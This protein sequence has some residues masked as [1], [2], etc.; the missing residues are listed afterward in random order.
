[1]KYVVT[2]GAGFIGSHL[3]AALLRRGHDVTVVDNLFSGT[4][5]NLEAAE[6]EAG[7]GAGT[8][9]GTP[10]GALTFV[11]ADILD[12]AAMQGALEG[13]KAVFHQAAIASVPRSFAEPAPSLRVN[14]EGTAQL[15]EACR[16]QDVRRFV[17]ASSSS[18]YGDTPT[19]P[20]HEGM[21]LTPLSPYAL[22][23]AADEHL[24]AIWNRQYG[25]ET[26]GL[27]Y[28]NIF[29]PR[30]DP[31]S[32][33]AAV[34][35]KFITRMLDGSAP[36]I[37]GDGGQSRDFTFIDNAVTANLYAGGVEGPETEGAEFRAGGQAM[38][39]GIGDRYTLLQ[40]VD[41]L[42]EILGTDFAPEHQ[43]PRVG[44]V[45]DSMAAIDRARELIG[46]EPKVD[47]RAGLKRTAAWY[48]QQQ[49]LPAA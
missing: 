8:V 31:N 41:G 11:E 21:P 5:A 42:N 9:T 47:F 26:V 19:L 4:R 39:I 13:A 36:I 29:G 35:P 37:Y 44:D 30:Q 33:Y 45:R 1:L 14:I 24:L 48:V 17:M 43:D 12:G 27:R 2:G 23:K 15:L 10:T 49:G 7:A 34:V 16:A 6:A 40:L 32:E 3:S 28:F 22:S 38:N 20:K 18:I 46:Y 25:L